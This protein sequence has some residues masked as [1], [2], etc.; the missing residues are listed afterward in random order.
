METLTF[1]STVETREL[2]KSKEV[3]G[4]F[5]RSCSHSM[6]GPLKSIAGLVG[7]LHASKENSEK[8]HQLFLDLI[9]KTTSK[10][11][12]M[13]DELEHFMENS[14]RSLTLTPTD[15]NEVLDGVLQHFDSEIKTAGI[16]INRMIDQ[17][18]P[19]YSDLP[20]LRLIISNVIENAI[21]FRDETKPE[22][23]ITISFKVTENTCTIS[24][25]DNGIGIDPREKT[26]I[27][28]LF[29]RA[30]EKSYGAGIGLY[31]VREVVEKMG[32]SVV[33]C[34]TPG[35]GSNFVIEMPNP[36]RVW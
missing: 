14:N 3:I 24:I 31:V 23:E 1:S 18:S 15:C 6:R 25:S 29:Y 10:M 12:H 34:S 33:V 17:R 19:L 30:T 16:K 20:R 27:F 28:Q 5:I 4:Q 7:L 9:A 35:E 22:T 26:N 21:H 8:N 11:E 36:C 13:L 2:E 32:G